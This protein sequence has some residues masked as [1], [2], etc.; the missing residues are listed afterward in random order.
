MSG[1]PESPLTAK[2]VEWDYKRGYGFLQ[3]GRGRVFLHRRDFAEHHK[4][5]AV[6]DVIRF[7]LGQDA[8]GRTCRHNAVHVNDGGRIT[9]V[10]VLILACLLVLPAIALHRRGVDFRWSGA[11]VLVIG[12]ISYGC[13][14][15]DK[16][17]AREQAWRIS[18]NSLHLTELLGGWPGA[19]LAQRRFRHKISKPGFQFLF[20]LIVLGYQFAAVDSLQNWR[21]SRAALDSLGRMKHRTE[22]TP[23]VDFMLADMG[24]GSSP[25]NRGV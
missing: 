11:Y 24:S 4:R 25:F 15:L 8:K 14:A 10:A 12:A 18:E 23:R 5:P 17:R 9:V 20:W 1:A 6:G 7:T 13:Y 2:I 22:A 16:R 21:F 19:F 3:V